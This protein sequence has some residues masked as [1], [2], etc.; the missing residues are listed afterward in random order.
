M[1]TREDSGIEKYRS[2]LLLLVV[3]YWVF[4]TLFAVS[5]RESYKFLFIAVKKKN[6]K[7]GNETLETGIIHGE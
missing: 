1:G 4:V 5:E 7:H 3:V 6:N 2:V